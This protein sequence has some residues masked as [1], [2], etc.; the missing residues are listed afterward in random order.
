M[1]K[2]KTEAMKLKEFIETVKADPNRLFESGEVREYMPLSRKKAWCNIAVHGD[3]DAP[4]V[5]IDLDE[6][7]CAVSN[8][9]EKMLYLTSV[10]LL[11]YFNVELDVFTDKEYDELYEEGIL[12]RIDRLAD[13]GSNSKWKKSVCAIQDDYRTLEKLLNKE[14]ANELARLNDPYKRIMQR[15]DDD[16]TPEAM[17]T[18]IEELKKVTD[19]IEQRKNNK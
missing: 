11:H 16:L 15:I 9:L 19:E 10:Y 13:R 1:R 3:E 17:Q 5:V 2:V 12:A 8:A 4:P 14:I 6:T 18:G 7:G